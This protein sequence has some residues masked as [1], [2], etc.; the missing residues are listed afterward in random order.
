MESPLSYTFGD[1]IRTSFG[2]IHIQM[3]IHEDFLFPFWIDIVD[4]HVPLILGLDLLDKRTLVADNVENR[5]VHKKHGWSLLITRAH[6]HLSCGG[7]Y[8]VSSLP[9]QNLNACTSTSS[10]PLRKSPSIC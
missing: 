2:V 1:S 5:L 3:Q 4:A 7:M 10:I 8:T 9:D 6:V